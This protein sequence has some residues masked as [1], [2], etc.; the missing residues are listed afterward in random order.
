MTS[1]TA[2]RLQVNADKSTAKGQ[3]CLFC[4]A[5]YPLYP[6]MIGGCEKC[7]TDTFKAPVEVVYDYPASSD[8]LPDSP[9]P[10]IDRYAP[11]LPPLAEGLSMGEGGTALVHQPHDEFELYVKDESRNPTWSHKDRL[12]LCVT[13][14]ALAVGAPGI[15]A[16]SS[17]NHGAAAAAYAARAGLPAIILC[18]PRPPAVASFMQAYGQ[19]VVAVPDAPMRWTIMSRVI[20]EMGYHP[21]SNYTTP[22]TNHPFGSEGYKTIAY[23]LF[24]QLGRRAPEAVFT[25]VG[26]AELTFGIHKGFKELLRYGLIEQ[27]PHII[28]CEPAVG[29]PLKRALEQGTP[30]AQVDISASDAYAIAVPVNGYR[31]TV[32]ITESEGDAIAI[33]EGEMR[34]A[35]AELGRTG[36]WGE[37]SSV[38]SYAAVKH[39]QEHGLGKRGP[40]VV[41]N[42][43]SGFKDVHTGEHSIP[44]IDGSWVAFQS[45]LNQ[46]KA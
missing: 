43:S 11:L 42:T 21:A 39:A 28:G 35:Q 33:T 3:R 34:I 45:I 6:P 32:A 24:L 38:I 15:V 26:Y 14:A 30:I 37:I 7:A 25:P 12:N 23:E 20:D 8:W 44:F 2:R 31:G 18:T 5:E 19:T 41:V 27:L 46:S 13:S 4:G 36:M 1:A 16:A 9:L 40:L 22:P 29:A 10:G 17:G